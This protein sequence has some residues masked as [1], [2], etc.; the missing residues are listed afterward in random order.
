MQEAVQKRSRFF[1]ETY[2]VIYE[3]LSSYRDRLIARGR[4][5]A[6]FYWETP[7]LCFITQSLKNQKLSIQILVH[8]CGML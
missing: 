3:H 7:F 6:K 2:P 5:K 4:T 1:A 8:L